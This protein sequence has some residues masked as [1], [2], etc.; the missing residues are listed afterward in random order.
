MPVIVLTD[1]DQKNPV[2][3]VIHIPN[4]FSMEYAETH[5]RGI[6][7]QVNHGTVARLENESVSDAVVR[8]L[9]DEEIPDS[10]GWVGLNFDTI[11]VSE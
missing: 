2:R 10:V 1:S 11:D 6:I 4:S 9:E 8:I 5:V 3:V 7:W